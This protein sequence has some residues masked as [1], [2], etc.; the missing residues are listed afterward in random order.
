M[1]NYVLAAILG[2]IGL[3]FALFVCIH[4]VVFIMGGVQYTKLFYRALVA[5]Y[6]QRKR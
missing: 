1:N 6:Q 4:I 5:A 2:A 3:P